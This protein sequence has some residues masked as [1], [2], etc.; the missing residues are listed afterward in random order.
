MKS[1]SGID[2]VLLETKVDNSLIGGFVLE[3]DGKL[4]DASILRDLKDVRKQFQDNEWIHK[5][6]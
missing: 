1:K 4:L 5:L 6:R 3:M 2:N